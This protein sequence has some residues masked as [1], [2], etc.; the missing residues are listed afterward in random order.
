M[1]QCQLEFKGVDYITRRWIKIAWISIYQVAEQYSKEHSVG[2]QLKSPF[3]RFKYGKINIQVLLHK[4]NTHLPVLLT[5][6]AR[7]QQWP[8]EREA[9]N[10][11]GN[12]TRIPS[13]II[14]QQEITGLLLCLFSVVLFCSI[15]MQN[16]AIIIYFWNSTFYR[17]AQGMNVASFTCDSF[18]SIDTWVFFFS[19][20]KL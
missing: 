16:A 7:E 17:M 19:Q 20:R 5:S 2:Q 10:T 8:Q 18:H 12:H 13:Q 6:F 3:N 4:T 1:S 14:L 15:I 9:S 11:R